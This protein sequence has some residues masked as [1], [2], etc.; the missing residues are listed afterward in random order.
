MKFFG[1][2]TEEFR[3]GHVPHRSRWSTSA[4]RSSRQTR[5]IM[6]IIHPHDPTPSNPSSDL[7]AVDL[8]R[9][10]H[11]GI[12]AELFAITSTAGSIDP[13]DEFDRAALA[14][15]VAAVGRPCSSCTPTTRTPSSTPCWRP[16]SPTWPRRSRR[17]RHIWKPRSGGSP[18][19]PHTAVDAPPATSGAGPSAAP[20]PRAVHQ[21]R[22]SPT[23]ISRNVS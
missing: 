7:A 12:R 9:D 1:S 13:A 19:S 21:R 3:N 18:T 6:T 4:R 16:T 23:W 8:Y 17:P 20:R 22:T 11:K 5:N 10:I 14:D 2:R 15:H